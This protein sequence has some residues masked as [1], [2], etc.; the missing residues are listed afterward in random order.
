[1]EAFQNLL[2]QAMQLAATRPA[3]AAHTEA[4]NQPPQQQQLL[5]LRLASFTGFPGDSSILE[6]LPA[7]SL[8]RLLLDFRHSS[9]IGGPALSA[10]LARLSN[11]QQLRLS[12]TIDAVAIPGRCLP[13]VAQLSRLT[14]LQL[15]GWSD[16]MQSLQ[17]LLAQP[18]P[19]LQLHLEML[20][21]PVLDL[22]GLTQL[23]QLAMM[24]RREGSRLPN[25]LQ[26]LH[27]YGVHCASILESALHQRQLQQLQHLSFCVSSSLGFE[28]GKDDR[29]GI[30]V[31]QQ[32]GAVVKTLLLRIG[33]LPNLQRLKLE[34][35]APKVTAATA[36]A[37]PQLPQLDNLWMSFRMG[38]PTEEQ[39]TTILAA[40][41]A[42]TSLTKL[43]LQVG[44]KD[45]HDRFARPRALMHTAACASLSRLTRLKDL[46]ICEESVLAP[47]DALALTA[48]TGLTRLA[49]QGAETG[50]TDKVVAALARNLTQL[51]HL[52]VRHCR[53]GAFDCFDEIGQLTH[54]TEL[55]LTGAGVVDKH[56]IMRL[57][58]LRNLQHLA[59][60]FDPANDFAGAELEGFWAAVRKQQRM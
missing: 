14:S 46:T 11:L 37:W 33:T 24:N 47:G 53:L 32:L 13:G 58:G 23:T 19:L 15:A 20:D 35:V 21:L 51:Q 29:L 60:D 1:V 38:I 43:H 3:V 56:H 55:R 50:V 2:Q 44:A 42:A 45:D 4:V 57:T 22:S 30:P 54:L 5:G 28:C 27:L 40:V 31:E 17:L 48:L 52:D 36:A 9:H 39:M 25:Q 8:K 16:H 10:A 34:Y 6:T 12:T 7:H 26:R 59:V 49:L 18:L 41:A